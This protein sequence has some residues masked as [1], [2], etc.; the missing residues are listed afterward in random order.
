MKIL[1][2]TYDGLS[3][4][5]GQS[6]VLPYLRGL[7]KNQNDITI[8]SFE[9]KENLARQFSALNEDLK[10]NKIKWI[11]LS[12]TKYPPVVSTVFDIFKLRLACFSLQ[13]KHHFQVVHC[14]SYITS[15]VGLM[16]KKKFGIKFIFDMRGFFADERVDGGLWDQRK[17]IY[18]FVYK[19]F[20]RKEKQFI[21]SADKI[22]S[23]TQAAKKIIS[24]KFKDAEPK[25]SVIP[26]CVDT[27]LFNPEK[28]DL[29]VQTMFKNKASI[30]DE[31]FVLSY[32]GGIG[33][34]YL[35]DEML[36]FYKQLNQTYASAKFL[37]ITHHPEKEIVDAAIKKNIAPEKIIVVK[38]ARN[39]VPVLL[40]LSTISIFF[41][42][43]SY[44]KIASS[45]TKQAE[46]LAMGIPIICNTN[47]G[48]T[49]SVIHQ[50]GAGLLIDKFTE[51]EYENAIRKIPALLKKN[52]SEIRTS[53]IEMFSLE[54]GVDSYQKIYNDLG[55][56]LL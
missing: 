45:P 48:D 53:G 51:D 16:L 38:A 43:P 18:R 31:T 34:W 26:C 15:F 28:L 39:E 55:Q 14:R 40:S 36:D 41:I 25:I 46:V 5:L 37:F 20:K 32:L 19:Y 11:V 21:Q 13:R 9:K 24:G 44:S 47:V 27:E 42:M 52:K 7:S 4:P 3:D 33:T 23:L 29:S 1:Y 22:V 30:K 6:Q 10:K 8:V 2:L 17:L 54:N 49:E 50:S 12:Y 56:A 35:L